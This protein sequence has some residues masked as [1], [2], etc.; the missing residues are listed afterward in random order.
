M[1]KPEEVNCY[2]KHEIDYYKMIFELYL[3]E[4]P[5]DHSVI[6]RKKD[7]HSEYIFTTRVN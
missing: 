6:K 2:E 3:N 1:L 5:L 7:V 4:C